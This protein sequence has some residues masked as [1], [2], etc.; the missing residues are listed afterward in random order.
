[1]SYATVSQLAQQAGSV[2]FVLI[3]I[4]ACIYAF[5]PCNKAEFDK[6]ARAPLDDEDPS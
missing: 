4:G 5:L 1:M 3:F 2:Y 6:A